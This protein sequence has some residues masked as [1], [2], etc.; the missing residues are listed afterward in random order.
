MLNLVDFNN[1]DMLFGSRILTL[2]LGVITRTLALFVGFGTRSR[3]YPWG[4]LE[5]TN[6][7]H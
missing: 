2:L 5:Q 6:T 7:L 4:W 1:S 3:L